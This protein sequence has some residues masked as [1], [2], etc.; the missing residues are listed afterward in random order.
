MIL[1]PASRALLIQENVIPGLRWLRTL[2]RGYI[3]SPLRCSLPKTSIFDSGVGLEL[4]TSAQTKQIVGRERR[5]REPKE[6]EIAPPRQLNRYP[7]PVSPVQR[8]SHASST[9][10]KDM[11][12][13][14]RRPHVFMSE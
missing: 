13:D 2:T 11:R 1:S 12:I 6:K 4:L 7:V 5:E 10:I 14:H 8:T 9:L 3:L